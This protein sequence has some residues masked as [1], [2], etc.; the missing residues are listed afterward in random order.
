V[1]EDKP[2]EKLSELQLGIRELFRI[3]V[4]GTYVMALLSL[5]APESDLVHLA[6]KGT[7]S[8]FVASLFFGLVGYAGRIH[9]RCFPYFLIFEKFRKP[10]ND[11]I[12][13]A[14]GKGQ[15]QDNVDLYKYFL[16]TSSTSLR[17]RIHYFSSF[18]YMLVELSFVSGATAL[19]LLIS[20]LSDAAGPSNRCPVAFAGTSILFG[21]VV[22]VALLAGLQ[23]IRTK[24][25]TAI[26]LA[27]LFLVLLGISALAIVAGWSSFLKSLTDDF[28][29][30]IFLLL[31]FAF[32]RLGAK[33]WKQIT[34]EQIIL[35]RDKADYL[36]ET[37]KKL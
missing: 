11:A 24:W 30:P 31:A 2:S 33:H 34:R 14:T 8:L 28:L 4:P 3:L 19:C 18:Y 15:G 32:E 10:L 16:E 29:F 17:D 9:E 37:S 13:A 7:S 27:P 25:M 35:V 12:I 22:Q 21:I 1:A 5:F 6:E 23:G 36:T 26:S 20:S